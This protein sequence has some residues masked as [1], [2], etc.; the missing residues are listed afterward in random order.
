MPTAMKVNE[1]NIAHIIIV[2]LETSTSPSWYD[3]KKFIRKTI[4]KNINIEMLNN[5]S[6]KFKRIKVPNIN[7]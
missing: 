1:E 3:I 4:F 5:S 2:K 6:Y 7:L